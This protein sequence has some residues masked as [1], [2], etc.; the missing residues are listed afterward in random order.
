MVTVPNGTT[1]VIS[2]D[3]LLVLKLPLTLTTVSLAVSER[4]GINVTD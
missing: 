3:S 4:L 2:N 1:I